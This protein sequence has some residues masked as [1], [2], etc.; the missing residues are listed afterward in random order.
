[1]TG[2]AKVKPRT[3]SKA[4]TLAKFGAAVAAVVAALTLAGTAMADIP[5]PTTPYPTVA[6][7][8]KVCQ[9]EAI[10]VQIAL[11]KYDDAVA[12]YRRLLKAA[13]T[14]AAS[15]ESLRNAQAAV[16]N[17]G[18]ALNDANYAQAT[19][20]NTQ[21][22]P[23]DMACI[24]LA[25]ELNRLTDDL[26]YTK[27]LE[28]IA[29]ANYQMALQL[30]AKGAISDQDFQ[31]YQTN[32]KLAQLQTKL[33]TQ[34]VADQQ[35]KVTTANCKNAT[36]PTP[37]A[38]PTGTPTGSCT[39]TDTPTATDSATATDSPAP[40]PTPTSAD[41]C[42]PPWTDPCAYATTFPDG[43]TPSPVPTP[44][45]IWTYINGCISTVWASPSPTD[46]SVPSDSPTPTP[47]GS[48]LPTGMPTPTAS[49]IP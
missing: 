5:S 31:A 28:S 17:A 7:D 44:T 19:C 18:I 45:D 2:H 11:V 6:I 24:N 40:S 1:M 32:Y 49:V 14:G 42:L 29:A 37:T 47:T 27:D 30:Q 48:T 46:T 21:A 39:S 22:A 35:A 10:K 9:A 13:G 41:S 23:A 16:D 26:A 20:Q 15:A 43:P 12:T 34:Q 8:P 25:L 38:T 33:V 4:R 3:P 36:R